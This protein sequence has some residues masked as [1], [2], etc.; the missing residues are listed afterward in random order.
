MWTPSLIYYQLPLVTVLIVI[1]KHLYTNLY[2][3]AVSNHF[4]CLV[5]TFFCF[6]PW[7]FTPLLFS[8][9]SSSSAL[10]LF[11]ILDLFPT[12]YK[13]NKGIELQLKCFKSISNRKCFQLF[14]DDLALVGLDSVWVV[15]FVSVHGA[16]WTARVCLA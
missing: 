16:E 10:F 3:P 5:S 12:T 1:L 14:S 4:H 11:L 8:T 13:F 6:L 2:L 9:A 15:S 7:V